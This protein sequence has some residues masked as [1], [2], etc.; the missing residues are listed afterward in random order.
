MCHHPRLPEV[1]RGTLTASLGAM[2]SRHAVFCV[3]LGVATSAVAAVSLTACSSSN[4]NNGTHGSP[5]GRLDG[6]IDSAGGDGGD[7]GDGGL[8]AEDA[9]EESNPLTDT[10][11]PPG[12][13][14]EPLPSLT[15]CG[16]GL[17]PGDYDATYAAA[18]DGG[19]RSWH[20]HV[21][22]G[23]VASTP[24]PV[25]LGFHGGGQNAAGF[26]AMSLLRAKSDAA[27]FILVEPEGAPALNNQAPTFPFESWNAGNCCAASATDDIDDV[28]FVRGILTT[29][30]SDV[31]FDASRVYATGFSNGAMF[32][33]RLACEASD[34]IAAIAPVSGGSGQVDIDDGGADYFACNPTHPM[35]ILDIHGTADTCYPYDGGLG[36]LSGVIFE[37]VPVTVATWRERNGCDVDAAAAVASTQGEAMCEAY[38]CPSN[39]PITLCTIPG[40]GHYWPG[41]NPWLG[42]TTLCPNNGALAPT[43]VANDLVW[44]FLSGHTLGEKP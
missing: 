1:D 31:C 26:E 5:N 11:W 37:G 14:A 13:N 19:T 20:V 28:G 17:P 12:A 8:G 21:P 34:I 6:S 40:G 27:S 24:L 22:S 23:Y 41:G 42:S 9:S 10:H 7:G 39:G 43:P 32:S 18:A 36:A 35:P 2:S 30:A 16:A 4:A 3:A 33:Y 44:G 29:L 15:S 25:L 38:S